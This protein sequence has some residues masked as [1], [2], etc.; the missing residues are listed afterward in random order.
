LAD[1]KISE[2]SKQID[3][4][5]DMTDHKGT[6]ILV[7]LG[8]KIDQSDLTWGE[9]AVAYSKHGSYYK[10]VSSPHWYTSESFYEL[11]NAVRMPMTSSDS[12]F[13][14]FIAL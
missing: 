10:G 2:C 7:K 5:D 6:S 14:R 4:T 13:L 11:V 1:M 12:H 8:L 9:N 3:F